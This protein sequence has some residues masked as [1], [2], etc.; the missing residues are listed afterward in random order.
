M[1]LYRKSL[2]EVKRKKTLSKY[3]NGGFHLPN[4][5]DLLLRRKLLG[6][7]NHCI[8]NFFQPLLH[9]FIIYYLFCLIKTKKKAGNVLKM[10]F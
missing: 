2:K 5:H 3:N 8:I 1:F 6:K 7:K 9:K 4:F 10:G